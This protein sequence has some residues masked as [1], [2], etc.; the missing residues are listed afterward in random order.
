MI[1][2]RRNDR[3][4]ES[5]IVKLNFGKSDHKM[6]I[7]LEDHGPQIK[8]THIPLIG[9][10]FLSQN[11]SGERIHY[12]NNLEMAL[13]VKLIRLIDGKLTISSTPQKTLHKIIIPIKTK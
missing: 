4:M 1:I 7:L 6:T 3:A 10:E 5:S 11:M 9:S 2:D 8:K 12:G 13:A